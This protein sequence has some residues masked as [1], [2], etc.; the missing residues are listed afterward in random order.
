MTNRTTQANIDAAVLH[1]NHMWPY[2]GHPFVYY[3]D[4]IYK[5]V[6]RLGPNGRRTILSARTKS[7]LYALI[8][9]FTAGIVEAS[10]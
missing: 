7:Q 6:H 10:R 2:G 8:E 4:G 1:L 9:A 3:S 5:S